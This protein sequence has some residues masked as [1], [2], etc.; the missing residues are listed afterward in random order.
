[1]GSRGGGARRRLLFRSFKCNALG[2]QEHGKRGVAPRQGPVSCGI[3]AVTL[4]NPSEFEPCQAGW[5]EF[6]V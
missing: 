6:C 4:M 1:M 5:R 2:V 3:V